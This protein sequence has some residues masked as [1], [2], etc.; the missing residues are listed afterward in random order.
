MCCSLQ[1]FLVNFGKD[2]AQNET[3]LFSC[4]CRHTTCKI[5]EEE[6][7]E[8]RK[9][10]TVITG[11]LILSR[12]YNWASK[13]FQLISI[14]KENEMDGIKQNGEVRGLRRFVRVFRN[15]WSQKDIYQKSE[16]QFS[17]PHEGNHLLLLLTYFSE[18]ILVEFSK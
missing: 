8:K 1:I 12:T 7:C 15:I 9:V 5:V 18:Y 10:C 4:K 3:T 13:L 17:F 6:L 14:Q 11:D 16:G 2:V